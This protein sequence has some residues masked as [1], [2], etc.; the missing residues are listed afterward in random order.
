MCATATGAAPSD[1]VE[2]WYG[3]LVDALAEQ[4]WSEAVYAA[5]I[6]S[7]YVTDPIH[8]F[9]TAQSEAENNIHRA[10][11]W[12]ISKSYDE[13][14]ED[15]RGGRRRR[16]SCRSARRGW[17][18]DL[19]CRGAEISNANYE[20]LIAHYDIHRGVV[21]PPAGPRHDRPRHGRRPAGLCGAHLWR[22]SST[23]RS[24]RPGRRRRT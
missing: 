8:P 21:D 5:G 11:E 20:R 9:H 22:R 4:R 17:L 7:H 19:V 1:K 6:L 2:S 23:A 14:R 3:Q 13:L 16:S 15:R 18:R 24:S 10:A 12:S